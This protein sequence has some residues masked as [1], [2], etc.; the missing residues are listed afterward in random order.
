MDWNLKTPLWGFTEFEQEPN[1]NT[2]PGSGSSSL[3]GHGSKGDFSVDLKLGHVVNR[4]GNESVDNLQVPSVLRMAS[5]SSKKARAVINGIQAATCLVDGCQAD[6]SNCREYH[7]RHKVCE[8]HSKTPEVE[9]NGRKRRFCQQCS[10]VS[11]LFSFDITGSHNIGFLGIQGPGFH[12]LEEFDEG[13]RSCRKRLDGHNRTGLF[14]F[15]CSEV[16]PTTTLT[17]PMW[18][19]V[20]KTKQDSK[21]YEQHLLDKQNAYPGSSSNSYGAEGKQFNFL[22]TVP[23]ASACQP[24]HKTVAASSES[25]FSTQVSSNCALSLLSSPPPPLQPPEISF[26]NHML[27]LPP[28]SSIPLA[29]SI[30]SRL[31][32]NNLSSMDSLLVPDSG[33]T[34]VHCQGMF[35]MGRDSSSENDVSQTLPFCWE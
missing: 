25:C 13:K 22:Q 6:L 27:P 32:T 30:N 4:V 2:G 28:P 19:G 34:G 29:H 31:H 21:L 1:S 8:R 7:R 14:P 35:H 18:P 33:D 15:S 10:R 23:E 20:V 17:N 3:G 24:F 26:K 16:Y 11:S 12:S 5:G 9:I